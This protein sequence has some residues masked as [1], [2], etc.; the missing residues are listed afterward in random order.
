[1][2]IPASLIELIVNNPESTA[3][4]AQINALDSTDKKAARKLLGN[5]RKIKAAAKKSGESMEMFGK[6]TKGA[7][8]ELVR[9][10]G[11]V[12]DVTAVL[13]GG[14]GLLSTLNNTVDTIEKFR[15]QLNRLAV[16]DSRSFIISLRRQND[17]L[18]ETI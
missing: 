4:E 16:E 2:A 15:I 14:Q 10:Q 9:F 7:F 17:A 12:N 1:M 18:R 5:Q 8:G 11:G 3:I 6:K 13:L